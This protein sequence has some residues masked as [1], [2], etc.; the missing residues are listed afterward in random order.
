MIIRIK[1]NPTILALELSIWK[2]LRRWLH[3]T[4]IN[5]RKDYHASTFMIKRIK[6]NP[7]ILT[8]KLQKRKELRKMVTSH[9]DQ[10]T[11]RLSWINLQDHT[12]QAKPNHLGVGDINMERATQDGYIT[13]RLIHEKIIMHQPSW[14]YASS[15]TPPSWFWSYQHGKSYTRWLHHT[16]INTRK[17]YHASTF[18]IIGI[19]QNP[20]ILAL[21]LSTWKEL[22]KMV[23]S[24]TD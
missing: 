21:E 7:T 17:D 2:E 18:M 8:L 12:H 6:H 16:P 1:H 23:T 14:S 19:K 15:I 3:H 4:P 24:H 13:H 22:H 11:K 9:T 20:T 5:T 10:Y